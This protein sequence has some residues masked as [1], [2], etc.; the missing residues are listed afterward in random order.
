MLWKSARNTFKRH[1][2]SSQL[3]F[4]FCAVC[5]F[6]T[7]VQLHGVAMLA[8]SLAEL[9]FCKEKKWKGT[10]LMNIIGYAW[11]PWGPEA[12]WMSKEFMQTQKWVIIYRLPPLPPTS[13]IRWFDDLMDFGREW[14]VWIGN[15]GVG[16]SQFGLRF[17]AALP[18]FFFSRKTWPSLKKHDFWWFSNDF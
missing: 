17:G 7:H 16:A 13:K 2:P 5:Q 10:W 14:G 8:W 9:C 3:C 11:I 18:G 6:F 12:P 1:L 15:G 4:M